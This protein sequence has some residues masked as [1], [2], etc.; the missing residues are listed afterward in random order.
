[1][2][3]I[4]G[5]RPDERCRA[6]G[7]SCARNQRDAGAHDL[8]RRREQPAYLRPGARRAVCHQACRWNGGGTPM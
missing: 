3:N 5:D 4:D 6:F 8:W 2:T 7:L 1:M